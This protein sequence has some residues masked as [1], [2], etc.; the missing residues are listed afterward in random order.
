MSLPG[1]EIKG[2]LTPT[3]KDLTMAEMRAEYA[4]LMAENAALKTQATAKLKLKV[5]S[6]GALSLYGMGRWPVTLYLTQWEDLIGFIEEIKA[7]IEAN[8][9]LLK[10]KGTVDATEEATA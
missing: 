9:S 6:K 2:R 3:S 4:K 1:I 8:R 7:F 5:S 10:T